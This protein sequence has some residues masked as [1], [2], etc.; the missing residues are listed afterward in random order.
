MPTTTEPPRPVP[1]SRRGVRRR[2]GPRWSTALVALVVPAALALAGCSGEDTDEP[3]D[4]TGGLGGDESDPTFDTGE[5]GPGLIGYRAELEPLNASGIEGFVTVDATET[6]VTVTVEARGV[7]GDL[8]HLQ[9]LHLGGEGRCP[10]DELAGDD[11]ILSAE[12]AEAAYGEPVVSLTLDGDVGADVADDLDRYPEGVD[13]AVGYARTFDLPVLLQAE[14]LDEVTY[15]LH[16]TVASP[17]IDAAVGE[18]PA[19]SDLPPEATVPVACGNLEPADRE[20]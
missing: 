6:D 19:A 5:E 15:V 4:V 17:D 9:H 13:G 2:R 16:G 1:R 18:S 10:D 12:E 7:S 14:A 8:A 20:I 11:R 3:I